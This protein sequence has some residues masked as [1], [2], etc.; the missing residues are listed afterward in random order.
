MELFTLPVEFLVFAL[1]FNLSYLLIATVFVGVS[2][3]ATLAT[4]NAIIADQTTRENRDKAFSTAFVVNLGSIGIGS[5]IPLAFP[6]I[7]N[8]SGLGVDLVH[9]A[10]MA[11]VSLAVLASPI[12]AS[13]LL[14]GYS[15]LA[16][17][18]GPQKKRGQSA[19]LA[20]ILL[21]QLPVGVWDGAHHSPDSHMVLPKIRCSGHLHWAPSRSREPNGGLVRRNLS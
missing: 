5:A 17:N 16:K 3:A 13:L 2:E 15:E 4:W 7:Q 11:G 1:T 21:P 18:E 6:A 9:R 19:D 10:F 12:L 8:V 14:R 20:E